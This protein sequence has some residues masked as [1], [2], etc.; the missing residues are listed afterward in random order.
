ME[1]SSSLL[2]LL[3]FWMAASTTP[4]LTTVNCTLPASVVASARFRYL[5]FY[6]WHFSIGNWTTLGESQ[7]IQE[8]AAFHIATGR[9]GMLELQQVFFEPMS[10]IDPTLRGLALRA[11]SEERWK[12]LVPAIVEA[13]QQGIVIGLFLGDE[14]VWNNI[15]W[16]VLNR[17][18]AMVKGTFPQCF[19]YYNEG[20]APLYA[21]RNINGFRTPYPSVP[22]S[23]DFVS[24]DDYGNMWTTK[25]PRWFYE[26]FLYP[27]MHAAQR[28]FVVPPV[29]AWVNATHGV[30][31]WDEQELRQAQG[32][33]EW[34]ATDS[35]LAGI[36]GFHMSSYPPSDL[37]L[38]SLPNTLLCYQTL[39]AQINAV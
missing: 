28:A 24:S 36:N 37:G 11:D 25:N 32:Y 3:L 30:P 33:L 5:T 1:L 22:E 14:L 17:T 18:A 6:A 23:F 19:L 8:L 20:G 9:G 34:I 10:N 16:D 7:S 21:L 2:F 29:Y 4:A 12:A 26:S 39:A 13:V 31:W 38:I 35:R 27:K 15:T